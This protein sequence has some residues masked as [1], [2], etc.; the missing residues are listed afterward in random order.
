[1]NIEQ[2]AMET[3]VIFADE[4]YTYWS[5]NNAIEVLERFAQAV[6]REFVAEQNPV[7]QVEVRKG[8]IV[9]LSIQQ[10]AGCDI[11]SGTVQLFTLEVRP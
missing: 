5:E 9:T 6:I 7:A 1:M 11:S 10:Y 3:G 2:I 4:S 8:A